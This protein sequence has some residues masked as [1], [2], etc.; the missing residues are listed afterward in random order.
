MIYKRNNENDLKV[1]NQVHIYVAPD[2]NIIAG[3]YVLQ[4]SDIKKIELIKKDKAKTTA[5]YVVGAIA[6]VGATALVIVGIAAVAFASTPAP[7]YTPP[8][9]GTTGS[10]PYISAYTGNKFEEQGEIYSGAIYPQ[11]ARNDY[12]PL[13]M[14]P[15]E[16]G[17]L[18]IKISNQLKD[19]TE[20]T[21]I[22]DLIV[23]THGNNTKVLP[24]ENG[25]L[26]SISNPESPEEAW[27]P[28]K[29]DVLSLV[30]KEDDNEMLH[31]DD[32]LTSNAGNYVITQFKNPG[33]IKKAALVLSVKNTRWLEYVHS[34]LVKQFGS[35]Y[36]SFIKKSNIKN[37][38]LNYLNGQKI[39]RFL[40][41]FLLKQKWAGKLLL[42]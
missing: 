16:N 8:P 37:P 41:R 4:L 13:L 23:V 24:D 5:S 1:F 40:Y 6:I 30:V 19:E 18:V 28:N 31:F 22:A 20:H 29:G 32:T 34:Q 25:N 10:C 33:N 12:M 2:T 38:H 7:V 35:Y 27:S 42:T 36:P 39:N 26:Y 11:L 17:K 3:N 15:D 14:S 9:G 21:D